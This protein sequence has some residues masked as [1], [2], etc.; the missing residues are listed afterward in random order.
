GGYGGAGVAGSRAMAATRH[1]I[2]GGG[3]AAINAITTIREIDGGASE[4]VLVA[5]ERPY[6]RMVLP[7]YLGNTIGRTH[8]FTLTPARL[9]ELG[10]NV[11]FV[12]RRA[13]GLDPAAQQ[14]TLDDGRS[15]E[16]DDLLIATGSTAVRAPV[17]G[18]D[19][20]GVHSFWTLE[21]A[22]GVLSELHPGCEVVLV[23]AGFIA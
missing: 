9:A 6:S 19:G 23:G 1:V 22:D 7:Y 8:V 2:V 3:T 20:P 10:V 18:A 15:V 17:P 16:Y 12:G 4:I 14:L 21:Q 11:S 13:V 5:D